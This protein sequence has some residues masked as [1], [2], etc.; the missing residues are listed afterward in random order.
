MLT[1]G[2]DTAIKELKEAISKE[3]A[4][5]DQVGVFY[6]NKKATYRLLQTTGQELPSPHANDRRLF[7]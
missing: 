5:G 2:R 3:L 1:Y 6:V 4:P 7:T